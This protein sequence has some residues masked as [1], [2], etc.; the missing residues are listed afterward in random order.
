MSFRTKLDGIKQIWQFDNR[1]QLLVMRLLFP[2]ES[3]NSY[4]YKGIEFLTD[5][6]NGDANGAREVLTTEM[7][8]RFLPEMNLTNPVN[9]LDIGA[10]NG[11]FPLLLLSEKIRIK[12]LA[13]VELNPNTF[14]RMRFNIERNSDSDFYP[15]N[16]AVCGENKTLNVNLGG[17]GTADN[18]YEPDKSGGV[19]YEVAGK[20]FDT[21][22]AEIFGDETVDICKIDIEGAE[23]EMFRS[24][25][26]QKLKNCRFVLMEIHHEKN[27]NR[28]EIIEILKAADFLE[29]GGEQKMD[30]NHHVHFFVNSRL[31]NI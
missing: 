29:T 12:K 21:I 8:R 4:K 7:Y 13:C 31:K 14:S 16:I 17:G 23:F 9:V 1:F 5:H 10:N 27:R 22:Y 25:T 2:G 24:G 3:L 6:R 15:L 19:N 30:E 28:T 26:F 20:T 11:G 18:I